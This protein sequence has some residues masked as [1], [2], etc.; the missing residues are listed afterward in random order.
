MGRYRGAYSIG[1]KRDERNQ[2]RNGGN[3]LKRVLIRGVVESMIGC[4]SK[5]SPDQL[6]QSTLFCPLFPC[7]SMDSLVVNFIPMQTNSLYLPPPSNQWRVVS[8]L[9]YFK[10]VTIF[11]TPDSTCSLVHSSAS[12]AIWMVNCCRKHI[13]LHCYT[14][15]SALH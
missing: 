2:S 7:F 1:G 8:L 12:P 5:C 3:M 11:G 13:L 4:T 14:V 6:L 9:T 15:I 10:I